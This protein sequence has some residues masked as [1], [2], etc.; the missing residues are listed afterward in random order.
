MSFMHRAS[1]ASNSELGANALAKVWPRRQVFITKS[2]VPRPRTFQQI[3]E[4]RRLQDIA[5]IKA[6]IS[7]MRLSYELFQYIAERR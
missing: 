3:T 2:A 7:I 5:S 1:S 4:N 6:M